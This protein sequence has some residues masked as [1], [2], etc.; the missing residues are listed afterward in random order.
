MIS[1]GELRLKMVEPLL[2]EAAERGRRKTFVPY[3]EY[4]DC[5]EALIHLGYEIKIFRDCFDT[6]TYISIE[7]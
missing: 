3:K 1:A 6:P 5:I 4:H 2:L 7:W